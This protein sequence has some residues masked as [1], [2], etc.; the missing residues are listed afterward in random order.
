[1]QAVEIVEIAAFAVDRIVQRTGY[2]LDDAN[3]IKVLA[4]TDVLAFAWQ[5]FDDE[6]GLEF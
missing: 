5:M 3:R 4:Q 1:V 2:P 6:P